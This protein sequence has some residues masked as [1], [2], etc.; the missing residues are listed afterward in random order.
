MKKLLILFFTAITCSIQAQNISTGLYQPIELTFN[1]NPYSVQDNPVR[2][3]ELITVWSNGNKSYS[4]YGFYDGDGQGGME[5]NI[6]KVRFCPTQAGQ[7]K[8]ERVTSNDLQLNHQKEGLV[9]ECT[10]STNHGFWE[11]DPDSPGQRWFKRSDGTHQY[12]S[13]NTL[14]SYLSEYGNDGPTGGNVKDDTKGSADYFNKV[15][16]S[17]SGDIFP[18]PV[19]KPFLDN[20]GNPTDDGNFSHRPNPKWFTERMDLAVNINYQQDVIAD[21][22]I[23][24]PDSKNSRSILYAGENGGDNIPILRYIAARY[25]SYP[26]VWICLSNEYNIRN[27]KFKEEQ[28]CTFGYRIQEFLPY[29]TPVSVHANQ[30]DWITALTREV[31]WNSHAILQNK[32]KTLHAAAD[33]AEKNY[34]RAGGGKPIVNDELAYQGEGDGWN[35]QDVIEAHLGAFLGA[36]YG[37]SGFKSGHKLG[38][39]FMGKFDINEHTAA[40]NLAWMVQV[41]NQNITFWKMT[42]RHY[43]Y[44]RGNQTGIFQNIEDTFRSIEWKNN[45]YVLGSNKSKSSLIANLPDGHWTITQYDIIAKTTKVI[46]ENAQGKFSFEVPDSRAVLT[47]IKKNL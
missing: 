12:F 28:I 23:N 13:G 42:P 4:I 30:H 39:Y 34:W 17:I 40:D 1:G 35:E 32:L 26:N 41:I 37:S 14:Y 25:G 20:Q 5:G 15:R 45:E 27:P 46:S 6:F 38:H 43:S 33:F 19:E 21:I 7:W 9:V 36:S 22:I 44:T 16:F 31:P 18:N 8:L 11:V 3:I 2:D 29:P 24:G 47:H 10:N